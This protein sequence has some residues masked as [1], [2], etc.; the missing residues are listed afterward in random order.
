[1]EWRAGGGGEKESSDHSTM[2][3]LG[4]NTQPSHHHQLTPG[5]EGGGGTRPSFDLGLEIL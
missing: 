3:Q 4:H 5:A 1:M 2:G